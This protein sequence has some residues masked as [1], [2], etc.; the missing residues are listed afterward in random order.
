M[1]NLVIVLAIGLGLNI[2][3]QDTLRVLFLGNSYTTSNNLPNLVSQFAAANGDVVIT[4]SNTP[5][6]HTLYQH[7]T[8]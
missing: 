5:G 3:A 4:D 8:N 6:G 1:K 2:Q 7:S